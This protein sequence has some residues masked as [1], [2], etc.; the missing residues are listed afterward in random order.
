MHG[1]IVDD[2]APHGGAV[3]DVALSRPAGPLGGGTDEIQRNVVGE[4]GPG[5]PREPQVDKDVPFGDPR[6][7]T[8]R[9]GETGD[10]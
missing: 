8:T 2:D 6:T 10:G 7:G 5:L 3:Q 9:D 1:M 4:R